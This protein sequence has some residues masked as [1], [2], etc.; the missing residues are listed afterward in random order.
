MKGVYLALSIFISQTLHGEL[1]DAL[2][3]ESPHSVLRRDAAQVGL[4]RIPIAPGQ[5][6]PLIICSVFKCMQRSINVFIL[7]AA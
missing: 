1:Q 4:I 5:L 2:G 7:A 3:T 6:D